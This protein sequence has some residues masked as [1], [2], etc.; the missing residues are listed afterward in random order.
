MLAN[1]FHDLTATDVMRRGVVVPKHMMLRSTARQMTEGRVGEAAVADA[2]G[3]CAGLLLATALLRGLDNEPRARQE[4]TSAWTE[5]QMIGPER[6]NGD[7]VR[8]HM[9]AGT[10]HGRSGHSRHRVGAARTPRNLSR[11]VVIDEQLRPLGL[12]ST[13]NVLPMAY[14][15][16]VGPM[17]VRAHHPT[18]WREMPFACDPVDSTVTSTNSF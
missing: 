10:A 18:L 3:R 17:A 4:P 1:E 11:A 12:V 2:R 15:P 6:G 8:H 14:P 16:A 5:W 7:D 13:T 9:T